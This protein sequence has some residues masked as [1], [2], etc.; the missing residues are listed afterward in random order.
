M[1]REK[2]EGIIMRYLTLILLFLMLLSCGGSKNSPPPV[3][4]YNVRYY[5]N[6]PFSIWPNCII[7]YRTKYGMNK[8]RIENSWL[9]H[10]LDLPWSYDFEAKTGEKLYL[11]VFDFSCST[12]VAS[13]M[14]NGE[15]YITDSCIRDSFW[16]DETELEIDPNCKELILETIL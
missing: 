3:F 16:G 5:V 1:A 6:C 2:V 9:E 11:R 15:E 14:L 4:E 13:I 7:E 8:V 12:T 10:G